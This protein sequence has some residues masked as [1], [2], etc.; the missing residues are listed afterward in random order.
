MWEVFNKFLNELLAN[1]EPVTVTSTEGIMWRGVTCLT[2]SSRTMLAANQAV[3][4]SALNVS[5]TV[6]LNVLVNV[7][8]N[9]L[10]NVLLNVVFNIVLNVMLNIVLNVMLNAVLKFLLNVVGTYNNNKSEMVMS[11]QSICTF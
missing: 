7:L 1:S 4:G 2:I 9:V 6:L 3:T 10:V 11:F 8:L 5:L